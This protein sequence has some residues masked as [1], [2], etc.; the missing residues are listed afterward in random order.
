M[1]ENK[2]LIDMQLLIFIWLEN[3]VIL[4]N[5]DIISFVVVSFSNFIV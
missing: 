1:F 4:K 2:G 3:K 5:G